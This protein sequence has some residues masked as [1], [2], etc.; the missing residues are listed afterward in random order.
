MKRTLW[1]GIGCAALVWLVVASCSNPLEVQEDTSSQNPV[2]TTDTIK[3]LDTI[4][5]ADT[6]WMAD[7]LCADTIIIREC[8]DTV[9]VG[10]TVTVSDTVFVGD[11]VTVTV[12]DTVFVGDTI[13]VSDTVFVGDTV[14]VIDTVLVTDTL[15]VSDTVVVTDTVRSVDTVVVTD[16]VIVKDCDDDDHDQCSKQCN[17]LNSKHKV[18]TWRL[19]NE[20]GRY[21][22]EFTSWTE[23]DMP[24]QKLWIEVGGQ[25]YAWT[26]SQDN[27]F[28]LELNLPA[29]ATVKMW[30]D[31]PHA[32]GHDIKVCLSLTEL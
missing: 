13:T 17:T 14:A 23:K 31:N 8:L 3:V 22:L 9:F 21:K 7:S 24:A 25:K 30:S 29:D 6:V 15:H 4:S 10:D 20:A 12:S 26:P 28:S 5:V 1:Y 11:T 27:E 19:D 18:I 2:F 32:Y 16:T